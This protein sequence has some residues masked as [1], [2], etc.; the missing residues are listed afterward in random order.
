MGIQVSDSVTDGWVVAEALHLPCGSL[1]VLWPFDGVIQNLPLLASLVGALTCSG[2]QPFDRG[3]VWM[4]LTVDM[5]FPSSQDLFGL[6]EASSAAVA[7]FRVS[8]SWGLNIC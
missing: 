4:S 5:S 2:A 7:L 3:A 6:T 8:F 1:T